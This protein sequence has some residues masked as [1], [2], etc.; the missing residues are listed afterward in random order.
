MAAADTGGPDAALASTADDQFLPDRLVRRVAGELDLC[1]DDPDQ[2]WIAKAITVIVLTD[3]MHHSIRT[4]EA[5][6][7][8]AR[9]AKSAVQASQKAL[10][11][12]LS[13]P[14]DS[15]A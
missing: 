1:V 14:V 3:R 7:D 15:R 4:D 8:I 9:R 6:A 13:V 11:E 12:L 10:A 2:F 5:Y